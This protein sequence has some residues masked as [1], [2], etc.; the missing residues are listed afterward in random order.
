VPSVSCHPTLA[1][2]LPE[3]V[4]SACR[5]FSF[6]IKRFKHAEDNGGGGGGGGGGVFH[7]KMSSVPGNKKEFL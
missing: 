3:V 4:V 6:N 1:Y 2:H 7:I 5:L